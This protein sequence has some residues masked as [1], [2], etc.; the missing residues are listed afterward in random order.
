MFLAL[1]L[2]VSGVG[3][4]KGLVHWF[5][6]VGI[7]MQNWY[8]NSLYLALFSSASKDG[9]CCFTWGAYLCKKVRARLLFPLSSDSLL[10]FSCILFSLVSMLR[11]LLLNFIDNSSSMLSGLL[12]CFFFL[13][14]T[15]DA[16]QS[17]GRVCIWHFWKEKSLKSSFLLG[18]VHP[19]TAGQPLVNPFDLTGCVVTV[20]IISYI[21]AVSLSAPYHYLIL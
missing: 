20:Q 18:L 10:C 16:T 3:L 8:K 12:V 2:L 5:L 15:L 9:I 13:F 1:A 14:L 17:I 7:L 11:K 19:N 4:M 6:L 21:K